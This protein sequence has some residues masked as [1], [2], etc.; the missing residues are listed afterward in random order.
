MEKLLVV[1]KMTKYTKYTEKNNSFVFENDDDGIG[2]IYWDEIKMDYKKETLTS[3]VKKM[4]EESKFEWE[5]WNI[6]EDEE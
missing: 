3:F 6:D 1:I 2:I 4:N 5:Y